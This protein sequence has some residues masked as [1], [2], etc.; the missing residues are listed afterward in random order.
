MA[1]TWL[2]P[3]PSGGQGCRSYN[4]PFTGP[5]ATRAILLSLQRAPLHV[6]D[7]EKPST[8]LFSQ[9]GILFPQVTPRR[10]PLAGWVLAVNQLL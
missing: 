5:P 1:S 6:A 7:S 2:Q 9:P 4:C 8:Q 3:A 10:L